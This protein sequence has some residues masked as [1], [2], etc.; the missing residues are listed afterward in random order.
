MILIKPGFEILN[1]PNN[2]NLLEYAGRLCYKT[3]DKTGINT[4]KF[5][6]QR[7][8]EGHESLIEHL[9]V[10]V[11]LICNRSVSH[12]LVRHRLASYSQESQRYCNY[13]KTGLEFIIPPWVTIKPGEYNHQ[14]FAYISDNYLTKERSW[15]YHLINSENTYNK[16]LL[17][18]EKCTKWK[19]EEA[20]DILPNATKTEIIATMNMRTWRHVLKLRTSKKAYSQMREIMI[21]LLKEFKSLFPSIFKD[22]I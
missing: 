20:R 12:E 19:P 2:L 11:K 21:P 9:S 14:N 4:D 13:N 3:E 22:I 10:S 16:L 17:D 6:E 15:F 5:L 1:K 18:E 7:I 8:R